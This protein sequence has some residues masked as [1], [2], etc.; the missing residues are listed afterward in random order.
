[1]LRDSIAI[2]CVA[3]HQNKPDLLDP[4]LA[5]KTIDTYQFWLNNPDRMLKLAWRD[6]VIAG[7]S[8][9]STAGE[10]LLNYVAPDARLC[11]VSSKLL[12]SLEESLVRLGQDKLSLVSTQTAHRF[13]LSRG[14]QDA[15]PPVIDDGMKTHP[16]HKVITNDGAR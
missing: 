14:W 12:A 1:M 3:D 15:G 10:I 2:L 8:L 13:Y 6:G 7:L 5:N 4:W 16:M 9:A 11:G